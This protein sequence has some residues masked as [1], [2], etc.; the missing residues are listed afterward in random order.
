MIYLKYI[1]FALYII[2][3]QFSLA[4]GADDVTIDR[5]SLSFGK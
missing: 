5:S 4:R 3:V 2:M 1:S